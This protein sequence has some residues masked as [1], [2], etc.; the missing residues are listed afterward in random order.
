VS[1]SD[2][3][4]LALVKEQMQR[5]D[6]TNTASDALIED[7]IPGVSEHIRSW[8]DD[9]FEQPD[10]EPTQ[11]TFRLG[12]RNKVWLTPTPAATITDVSLGHIEGTT[13]VIDT[14]LD[15]TSWAAMVGP[16]TVFMDTYRK[17]VITTPALP[18]FGWHQASAP[19]MAVTGTWG[20]A[21]LPE[22]V[23]RA[24]AMLTANMVNTQ[25]SWTS[26]QGGSSG[27]VPGMLMPL[28][29]RQLLAAWKNLAVGA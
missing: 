18:W 4:T 3:T 8:C 13:L 14:D 1:V 2:L 10:D 22:A 16:D 6:P 27:G 20:Y 29:V 19:V 12:Y 7:L 24:A 28:S 11:R 21:E 17:I 26:G 9:A 5:T 23:Q 15:T 25:N